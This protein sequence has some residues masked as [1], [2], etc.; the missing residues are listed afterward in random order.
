MITQRI[1]CIQFTHNALMIYTHNIYD[2]EPEKKKAKNSANLTRGKFNGTMSKKTRKDIRHKLTNYYDSMFVM[3]NKWRKRNSLHHTIVTL[4]L[5]SEQMHS[6]NE[7]KRDC[8]MR[9]I[10]EAKRKHG[11]QFYYWVAEKQKKGN[12]HFHILIDKFI[13]HTW[14][15][16]A[17]NKEIE[18]LGY[19][20]AFEKVHNH[21]NP[22][23]TDIE[24]I[25]NLS[26]SSMYVTKYTSK[27]NQQGGIEGRLHGESDGL[28][29][30]KNLAIPL[31]QEWQEILDEM[32]EYNVLETFTSDYVTM[33]TGEVMKVLELKIPYLFNR[34]QDDLKSKAIQFYKKPEIIVEKKPMPT[35]AVRRACKTIDE[36]Y[37]L[38]E[39][40]NKFSHA[41]LS[42][43]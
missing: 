22:N 5:P 27:V 43:A 38:V 41:V 3:G 25:K 14:V 20:D 32:V 2:T 36:Y 28:K 26:K 30:F 23:S 42:Y 9:F 24:T 15:R 39:R 18:K 1:P 8:L 6:D 21:R 35:K 11:I 40:E 17:W 33:Y 31:H 19:I 7:L 4:T 13:S 29:N 12:I 34:I 16:S 10:E 37:S